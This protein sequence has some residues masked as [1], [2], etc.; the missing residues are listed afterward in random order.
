MSLIAIRLKTGSAFNIYALEEN[1][2]CDLIDFL[3]NVN[4]SE[5]ARRYLDWTKDRGLI[6]NEEQSK[7]LENGIAYFRTRG[8]V[9]L[10]YFTD[11]NRILVCTNAYTKKKDKLDPREIKR[12]RIWRE[13]YFNAKSTNTIEFRD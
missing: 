8:G 2:N 11:A 10:F 6:T 12:A 9:R 4:A 5:A 3:E 13:K 1:G 7:K